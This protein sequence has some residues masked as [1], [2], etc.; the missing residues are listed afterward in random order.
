MLK[1]RE[2]HSF[3]VCLYQLLMN[4][5]LDLIDQQSVKNQRRTEEPEETEKE[6]LWKRPEKGKDFLKVER[7]QEEEKEVTEGHHKH[8]TGLEADLGQFTK[9][10]EDMKLN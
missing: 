7:E 10:E 1:E 8:H 6:V 3:L 4:Q 2:I 5:A 9:K